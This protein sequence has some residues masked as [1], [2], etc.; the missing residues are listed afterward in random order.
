MITGELPGGKTIQGSL[1]AEVVT[2]TRLELLRTDFSGHTLAFVAVT[3]AAVA[4]VAL[5]ELDKGFQ[6]PRAVEVRSQGVRNKYLGVPDLPQ[7]KIADPHLAA[8]SNE[9]IRI[10]QTPGIKVPLNVGFRQLFRAAISAPF[11]QQRIRGIQNLR[12]SAIVQRN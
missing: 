1:A 4:P 6:Q 3:D 9:Q 5:L 2:E 11:S 8:G 10:G 12:A 7:Q